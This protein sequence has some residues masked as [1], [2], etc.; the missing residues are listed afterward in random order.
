MKEIEISMHP[1]VGYVLNPLYQ[2]GIN[3]LG[4]Y[5]PIPQKQDDAK[6]KVGIF[7]GSVAS[8]YSVMQYEELQSSIA[9]R[10]GV[11]PNKVAL[12]SFALPGYKQPQQLMALTYIYSLGYKFDLVL[13]IDG[14]NE[15][16]LSYVESYQKGVSSYFPRNWYLYSRGVQQ[17]EIVNLIR[18]YHVLRNLQYKAAHYTWGKSYTAQKLWAWA[19]YQVLS[20][21]DLRLKKIPSTYQTQGPETFT[22]T[23]DAAVEQQII[24]TWKQSTI[25]MSRIAKA[26]GA[27]YIEFLQPNQYLPNTKPYSAE[28]LQKFINKN[29]LYAEI[30][31]NMYPQLIKTARSFTS[32]DVTIVDLS[33]VFA[34]KNETLY[35][36]DCCHYNKRGYE[37]LTSAIMDTLTPFLNNKKDNAE[38]K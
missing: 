16:A 35:A 4:Y 26:N 36:D 10:L 13:N 7:G 8:A 38:L 11:A 21:L 17:F 33:H 5:G 14:F 20:T 28:E 3:T 30:T 31:K 19:Y 27:Q 2:K 24:D 25:Q 15:V 18:M 37:I 9:A 23:A 22:N 34:H 12:Y 32:D 29:H 6:Y 1:Y